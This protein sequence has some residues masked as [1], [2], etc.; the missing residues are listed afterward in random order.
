[1]ATV[2]VKSDT[3]SYHGFCTCTV[4]NQAGTAETTNNGNV[5]MSK[6]LRTCPVHSL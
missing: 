6:V 3:D 4:W 1:L 5:L 2:S